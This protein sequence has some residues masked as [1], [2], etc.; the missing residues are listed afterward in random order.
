MYRLSSPEHLRAAQQ[1]CILNDL[2]NCWTVVWLFVDLRP[3]LIAFSRAALLNSFAFYLARVFGFFPSFS[4]RCTSQIGSI[5]MIIMLPSIYRAVEWISHLLHFTCLSE[6][7]M[8]GW[9]CRCCVC[10]CCWSPTSRSIKLM[11][12]LFEHLSFFYFAQNHLT[13]VSDGHLLS[14]HFSPHCQSNRRTRRLILKIQTKRSNIFY[15]NLYMICD[16]LVAN[17]RRKCGSQCH[18]QQQGE[19][20]MAKLVIIALGKCWPFVWIG[21][22]CYDDVVVDAHW[23]NKWE[24]KRHEKCDYHVPSNNSPF[25]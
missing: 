24:N 20:K 15:S 13:T 12:V 21:L 11:V 23:K 22:T 1:V 10:G 3:S 18:Q 25:P 7:L 14:F 19:E 16:H 6:S 2:I 17:R 4:G 5:I 8:F 9:W